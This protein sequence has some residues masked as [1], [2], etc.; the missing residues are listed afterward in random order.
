MPTRYA[1]DD[2]ISDCTLAWR[3]SPEENAS[4]A[5]VEA[6]PRSMSRPD[7]R[8]AARIERALRDTGYLSLRDLEIIVTEGLVV[9]RG[10][11]PSY[12]LKQVAHATAGAVPGVAEILDEL[13][14]V[15]SR[16]ARR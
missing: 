8:M 2:E 4:C 15:S 10:R 7:A 5:E 13:D 9:L 1:R 3:I 6:A 12:Y 11:L 16:P 14:V